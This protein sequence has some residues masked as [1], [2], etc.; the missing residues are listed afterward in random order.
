MAIRI[1]P[2]KHTSSAG[3]AITL[4]AAPGPRS[5]RE[6]ICRA[7]RDAIQAGRLRAGDRLPASRVLADDLRVS[8]ITAEGAY[9]QLVTEGYVTRRVGDG[10]Y[11][12]I[13]VPRAAGPP[14]PRGH[15]R[16]QSGRR[17]SRRGS[18]WIETGGCRDPLETSAFSAG[19]P[20]LTEFPLDV[21]KR[22]TARRLR[23]RGAEH[24][25]YGPPGGEPALR[26]AI[27]T[28]VAQS[29]GVRCSA[30]QVV[31]LT[32]SQQA[33]QLAGALLT[34]PGDTAWVEDPGYVGARTALTAAGA[35]LRPLRVD[36]DGAE[37]PASTAPPA[38]LIYLTPSHQYPMG[39]TLSLARR[40]E[41]IERARRMRAW[42]LEDDY[43][44]EFQ[45]DARPVP[46]LQGL[47]THGRVLY[48]GTFSKVL[49]PGL[50][51]AYLVLPSDLVPGVIT[52]RTALDGHPARLAQLVTADFMEEGHFAA[53]VR[54]MRRIYHHRRDVLLGEISR[55][56][57]GWCRPVGISAGLQFAVAL[58]QGREAALTRAAT[59]AGV[60]VPNMA[61]LFLSRPRMDGWVLGFAALTDRAIAEGVRR[62]E[63]ISGL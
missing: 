50:R 56:L 15:D 46:A 45:F 20:D 31:V 33:I 30:E 40:L 38:R 62:L 11:V 10:T 60:M 51:L 22:L 5:L 34:D 49:F 57:R 53:H 8:R 54:R 55:R 19:F 27:A 44:S 26:Q 2:L 47:D 28:Y 7:I 58:P 42:I 43:D 39:V 21:W 16:P 61:G 36:E 3:S 6:R 41:F 48:L 52:A 32:S 12:R 18:G 35:R 13:D 1:R 59:R 24:L 37:P 23:R 29:R 4:F 17:W 63:T 14:V 25:G 9:R